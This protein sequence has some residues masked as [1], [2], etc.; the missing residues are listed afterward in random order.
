MYIWHSYSSWAFRFPLAIN[1][2]GSRFE[3]WAVAGHW[4]EVGQVLHAT[5]KEKL[6]ASVQEY[7]RCCPREGPRTRLHLTYFQCEVTQVSPTMQQECHQPGRDGQPSGTIEYNVISWRTINASPKINIPSLN[8][9]F[10]LSNNAGLMTVLHAFFLFSTKIKVIT[11]LYLDS[12][13]F[14]KIVD[15]K[16]HFNIITFL[17][18]LLL[19]HC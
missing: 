9:V 15:E 13:I 10:R 6:P 17:L 2:A 3:D 11:V 4:G 14:L 5:R 19:W 12:E 8:F 16:G 18:F 1:I 7:S